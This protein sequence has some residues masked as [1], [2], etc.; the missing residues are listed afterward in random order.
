MLLDARMPVMD[1]FEAAAQRRGH[2][3]VLLMITTERP[4]DAVRC[5][6]AGVRPVLKPLRRSELLECVRF[7]QGGVTETPLVAHGEPCEFAGLRILLADDSEDNRFLIRRFL[8]SSGCELDE[9]EDGASLVRRF[10]E[11]AY[12]LVLADVQMPVMDGYA[13]TRA[14]RAWE[15]E[16]SAVPTPILA[17]T[18]HAMKQEMQKSLDAGCD[19]HLT[20]PI[21]KATLLGAIRRYSV[22]RAA[23]AVAGA[24]PLTQV[25]VDSSLEDI[26]PGYLDN[27]RKDVGVLR[28]ALE[29]G[30]FAAIRVLGHNMKGSGGGY[31]FAALT[32]LGAALEKAALAGDAEAVR[33]RID[34]LAAY[35]GSLRIKYE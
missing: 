12:S 16:R 28:Q 22:R 7:P 6:E 18:A 30:D 5:R 10:Q 27:R 2:G 33:G 31:G 3:R 8:Q 23:A 25:V 35:L 17:L 15:R 1:G 20:K 24:A 4:A 9:C 11:G 32:E 14:M 34:E 13:A 19:A 26:V 29:R 21:A